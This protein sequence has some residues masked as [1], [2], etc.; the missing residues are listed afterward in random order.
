MV[1]ISIIVPTLNE[2]VRLNKCL[3]A[4]TSQKTKLNYE[5][6]IADSNSNDETVSVAE[7][8]TNKI[9]SIRKK[10]IWRARN[11]G[12]KKARSKYFCFIDAD[13]IIPKNYISSVY[14]II[15]GDKSIA[16]LSCAFSFD[17]RRKSLKIV[18]SICNNYLAIR[19]LFGKGEILG[20]NNVINKK[21]FEKVKGYPNKPLEDGA[22]TIKLRKYGKVVYL[23]EPKVITSSRRF[24]EDGILKTTIYYAGLSLA[25]NVSFNRVKKLFPYKRVG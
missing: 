3:K 8:Y 13:T 21:Y 11:M 19:G 18:E 23:T 1:D 15:S 22:I 4:I 10:G 16:G 17:K 24:E 2:G 7:K 5:L 25:T 9:V 20:F 14:P 6:I 12:A